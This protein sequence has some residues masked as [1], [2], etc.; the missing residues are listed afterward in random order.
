MHRCPQLKTAH[1]RLYVI[2]ENGKMMREESINKWRECEKGLQVWHK[3][4]LS[5]DLIHELPLVVSDKIK[6]PTAKGSSLAKMDA[7]YIG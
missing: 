3:E 4:S 1:H 6:W 5:H 7:E 2:S